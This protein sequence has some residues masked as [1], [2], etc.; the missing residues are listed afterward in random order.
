M[1]HGVLQIL[2]DAFL[3]NH[4][5]NSRLCVGIELISIQGLNFSHA[6]SPG[7]FL[8][9]GTVLEHLGETLGVLDYGG[10]GRVQPLQLRPQCRIAEDLQTDELGILCQRGTPSWSGSRSPSRGRL[11][12][13]ARVHTAA[14]HIPNMEGEHVAV[15]DLK[16]LQ[17]FRIVGD[18]LTVVVEMLSGRWYAFSLD[19]TPQRLDCHFGPNTKG[20]EPQFLLLHLGIVHA[21]CDLPIC[22]ECQQ[23]PPA[24]PTWRRCRKL[25]YI[26][27]LLSTEKMVSRSTWY[28]S[29]CT[30]LRE[31]G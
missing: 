13:M 9:E 28:A 22:V 31:R 26:L 2:Y 7:L 14:P 29:R 8:L 25:T 4:L 1:F 16:L 5:L 11:L 17:G 12:T 20:H 15:G 21:E 27:T 23:R 30:K 24:G 18:Q 10:K 3:T 19:G 6:R